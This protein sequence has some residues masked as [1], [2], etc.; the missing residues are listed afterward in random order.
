MENETTDKGLISKIYKLLVH[1]NA[2][3]KTNQKRTEDLNKNFSK[4]DIQ[5][6]NKHMKRWL[7]SLI[8]REIQS[9]LQ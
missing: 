8:I 9:K 1:V 5:M 3:R 2:R 4:E 7:I 6:V